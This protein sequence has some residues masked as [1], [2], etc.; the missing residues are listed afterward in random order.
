MS[1]K[2][3]DFSVFGYMWFLARQLAWMLPQS[4]HGVGVAQGP[5]Q[6]NEVTRRSPCDHL[7]HPSTPRWSAGVPQ[8]SIEAVEGGTTKFLKTNSHSPVLINRTDHDGCMDGCYKMT[9]WV[10]SW[11]TWCPGDVPGPYQRHGETG[12]AFRRASWPEI[13]NNQKLNKTE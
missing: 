3:L 2:R 9:T 1:K 10:S 6:G 4:L 8:L 5:P 7:R 13:T 12:E 11:S